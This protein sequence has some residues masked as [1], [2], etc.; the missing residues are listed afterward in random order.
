MKRRGLTIYIIILGLVV[1]GASFWMDSHVYRSV[2][3]V[4]LVDETLDLSEWQGEPIGL[5]GLWRFYP[6]A[7]YD[8]NLKAKQGI[9]KSVP[10]SWESDA[11]LNFSPYGVGVYTGRLTGLEPDEIY[12]FSIYD[13]VT[14]YNLYINGKRVAKNGDIDR[15]IPEWRPVVGTFISDREGKAE[16][17]MEISNDHYYRGGFWNSIEIGLYDEIIQKWQRHQFLSAFVIACFFTIGVF[18][19]GVFV[20]H[21]RRLET[22]YFALICICM[23]VYS[24]LIVDRLIHQLTDSIPW[25]ILVRLEYATGYLLL[26]L[27][28]LFILE[29][30][31]YEKLKLLEKGVMIVALVLVGITMLIDNRLY[32]LIFLPYKYLSVICIG[33]ISLSLVKAVYD[34]AKGSYLMLTAC[35]AIAIA[36][37]KEFGYP[38]EYSYIPFAGLVVVWCFSLIVIEGF[39]TTDKRN[40]VLERRI[41]LDELTGLYNRPYILSFIER[42]TVYVQDET[43]YLLFLDLDGFKPI[44]DTYGHPV[45]DQIL[46]KISRALRM[47]LEHSDVIARFGGD[48]FL[49]LAQ[50][51]SRAEIEALA[52]KLIDIVSKEVLVGDL[53]LTVGVSIGIS[54]YA[55][56]DLPKAWI[57]R[58]DQAMYRSKRGGSNR[59]TVLTKK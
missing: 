47:A 56:G 26:P 7:R 57:T 28:C 17:V 33:V 2:E 11:D 16:I 25:N 43:A 51:K 27:F 29:L 21:R 12:G 37:I 13:E 5:T 53:K 36:L 32:T 40:Q 52:L 9:L 34:G 14:A 15:K 35:A 50:H 59:Y 8:S 30:F 1:L 24:L 38:N 46:V 58:S 19:L 6:D 44:N 4:P 54:P 55:K 31:H 42:F 10:H 45:G 39:A 18:F 48:E 23:S 41:V 20:M 49:I 22:L 3:H